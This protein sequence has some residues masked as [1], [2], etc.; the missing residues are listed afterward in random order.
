MLDAKLAKV[1]VLDKDASAGLVN[2]YARVHESFTACL[3]SPIEP[4][5]SDGHIEKT[6]ETVKLAIRKTDLLG[7]ID[8]AKYLLIFPSCSYEIV[9]SIMTSISKTLIVLGDGMESEYGINYTVT[10][11]SGG[12]KFDLVIREMLQKEKER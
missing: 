12:A 10:H 6:L 8:D 5:D 11:F 9:S 2:G 7:Y 3:F 1:G 4:D